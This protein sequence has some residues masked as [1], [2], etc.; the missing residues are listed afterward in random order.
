[1]VAEA[2][3][4]PTT[5]WLWAKWAAELL[6]SAWVRGLDSNQRPSAYEA[7]ELPPALPRMVTPRRIELLPSP[8]KGDVLNRLTMGPDFKTCCRKSCHSISVFWHYYRQI[9]LSSQLTIDF[10]LVPPR[11]A[12]FASQGIEPLNKFCHRTTQHLS[13]GSEHTYFSNTFNHNGLSKTLWWPVRESNPRLRRE[14]P[15]SWPLD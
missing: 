10:F 15:V 13:L 4:E 1:M 6:Y 7:D 14:R 3:F 11:P 8:W 9:I 5:S 2:G 12:P